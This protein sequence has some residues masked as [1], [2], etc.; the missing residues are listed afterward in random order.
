MNGKMSLISRYAQQTAPASLKD[1]F[2]SLDIWFNGA[3]FYAEGAYE[4]KFIYYYDS[5]EDMVAKA[6]LFQESEEVRQARRAWLFE[7]RLTILAEWKKLVDA[8]FPELAGG[9]KGKVKR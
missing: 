5:F 9:I 3:D 6:E 4:F 8:N 7:R 2:T 1:F